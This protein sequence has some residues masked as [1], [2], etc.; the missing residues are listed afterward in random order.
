[1]FEHVVLEKGIGEDRF[2]KSCLFVHMAEYF[3][4]RF[5]VCFFV[6]HTGSEKDAF[7]DVGRDGVMLGW[8][9]E[10]WQYF[11]NLLEYAEMMSLH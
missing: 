1:M 11:G 2:Q 7:L 6:T 4:Y 5:P 9:D 8:S 10:L 3:G